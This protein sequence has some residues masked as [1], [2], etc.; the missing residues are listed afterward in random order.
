M[1]HVVRVLRQ[2]IS[3][4]SHEDEISERNI[5]SEMIEGLICAL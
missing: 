2:V 3:Y 5:S 1:E 4:I